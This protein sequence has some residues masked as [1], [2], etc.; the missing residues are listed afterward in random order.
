MSKRILVIDDEADLRQL[1][2]I[3]LEGYAGWQVSTAANCRDGLLKAQNERPDLTLL[4]ISMPEVDGYACFEQLQANPATSQIPVVVLTAKVFRQDQRQLSQ[5]R[6][7][8]MIVKPFNPMTLW[9]EI[10][11]I[12]GWDNLL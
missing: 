10:A 12:V 8:G 7:A 3:A 11:K 2:Q 1:I 6:I 5:M 4:D 9:R